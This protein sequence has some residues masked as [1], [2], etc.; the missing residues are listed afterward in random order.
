MLSD[1]NEY[2]NLPPGIHTASEEEVFTCFATSSARRQWLGERLREVILI[3]RAT[4]K[5]Q[6]LILWG[7]FVTK[8]ESPDDLDLLL[9]MAEDFELAQV[10]EP[11][12]ILFDYSQARI[13]FRA[14][15]FWTK[16]SMPADTLAMWLDT[17]QIGK[18]F[19]RR[20]IVEVIVP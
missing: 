9:V 15:I 14:D 20:G 19:Q 10:P 13:R 5:L 18:D 16:M 4:G 8:K 7:S 11:L 12:R 2:G 3:A 1:F 6:R 17:Y